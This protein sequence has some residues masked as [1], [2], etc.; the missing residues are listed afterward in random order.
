VEQEHIKDT[1]LWIESGAPIFWVQ[2]PDVSN[3]HLW[4]SLHNKVYMAE[5]A[6]MIHLL[7]NGKTLLALA[8]FS[9]LIAL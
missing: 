6:I 2:N 9:P 3:K 8:S 1:C 4:K 7:L 5:G